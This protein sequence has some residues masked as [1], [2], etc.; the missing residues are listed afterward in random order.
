M[1]HFGHTQSMIAYKILHEYSVNFSERLHCGN[2]VNMPSNV[3]VMQRICGR[4]VHV[5]LPILRHIVNTRNVSD[6]NILRSKQFQFNQQY[7]ANLN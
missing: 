7:Y 2:V 5:H 4:M 6:D 1:H 3:S